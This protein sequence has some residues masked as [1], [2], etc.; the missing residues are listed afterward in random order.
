LTRFGRI[1]TFRN[2]VFRTVLLGELGP[3]L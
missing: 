1:V 3:I 2:D